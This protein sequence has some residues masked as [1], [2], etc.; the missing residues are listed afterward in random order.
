[1]IKMIFLFV[2]IFNIVCANKIIQSVFAVEGESDLENKLI[3][4]SGTDGGYIQFRK[5]LN[6]VYGPKNI[7]KNFVLFGKNYSN[8]YIHANGFVSFNKCKN[9]LGDCQSFVSLFTTNIGENL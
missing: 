3:P 1:M 2:I 6:C 4:Y 8:I 9:G 7:S 5:C